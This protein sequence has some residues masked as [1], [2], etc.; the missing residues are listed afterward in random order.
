VHRPHGR[1]EGGVV[2]ADL[3]DDPPPERRTHA[4]AEKVAP[5]ASMRGFPTV[6]EDEVWELQQS[7]GEHAAPARR[8]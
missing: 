2:A 4:G 5:P 8:R 6:A 7:V 3:E 1:Q